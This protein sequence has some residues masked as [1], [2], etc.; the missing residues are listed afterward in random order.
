MRSLTPSDRHR[1]RATPKSDPRTLSCIP[2]YP[3]STS[4]SEPEAYLKFT[5]DH[6]RRKI[7]KSLLPTAQYEV[8][9]PFSPPPLF[10]VTE[11]VG[12][13]KQQNPLA[14][15]LDIPPSYQPSNRRRTFILSTLTVSPRTSERT[16][17]EEDDGV[18]VGLALAL[19]VFAARALGGASRYPR[20][21]TKL[22]NWLMDVSD[23]YDEHS[24]P[25]TVSSIILSLLLDLPACT[26]E[27]APA[28]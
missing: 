7:G 2:P 18:L 15:T 9:R 16:R 5:Y 10:L 8:V 4:F 24:M 3:S 22:K 12:G 11:A 28:R 23:L 27:D 1:V 20:L 25:E 21:R 14:R 6:Q 17:P 19:L 26:M 13:E